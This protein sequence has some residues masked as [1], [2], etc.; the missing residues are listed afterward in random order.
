MFVYSPEKY[1]E[2]IEDLLG[3]DMTEQN[4]MARNEAINNRKGSE[5]D[6]PVQHDERR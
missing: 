6:E 3:C 2:I 4:Q 1:N 5:D